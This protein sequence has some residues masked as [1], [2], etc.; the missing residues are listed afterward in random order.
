MAGMTRWNLSPET[1]ARF[2]DS[3]AAAPRLGIDRDAVAAGGLPGLRALIALKQA[4]E[5]GT[6]RTRDRALAEVQDTLRT[7]EHRKYPKLVQQFQ[8]RIL[9]LQGRGNDTEIAH[10]ARGEMVVPKALQNPKVLA[11]LKEAAASH[12]FSVDVL[13]VGSAKN[14]IN[15][16]TGAPEFGI[17][18]WIKSQ[19][20]ESDNAPP[21]PTMEGYTPP[22]PK[23]NEPNAKRPTYEDL[24]FDPNGPGQWNVALHHPLA[25]LGARWESIKAEDD[26][27]KRYGGQNPSQRNGEAD[28][29]RHA[30]WSH[31]MTQLIGPELAKAFADAHEISVP[32]PDSERL[33]D[34][35]NNQIGRAAP[36][37]RAGQSDPGLA[38]QDA[39]RK[40][41]L[42]TSPFD[43]Q[44]K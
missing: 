22:I 7:L 32:N 40:G 38:L 5:A 37:D 2:N 4:A 26:A 16:E 44:D 35:Y 36:E 14:R 43:T 28:A 21:P 27:G 41:Y 33:M 19:F 42:R 6:E 13:R 9:A 31:R 18:D 1:R 10:V 23:V 12:G 3:R 29:Y 39:I 20:Q 15:P 11:A 17:M 25:A 30:V 24:G 34:L 8:A